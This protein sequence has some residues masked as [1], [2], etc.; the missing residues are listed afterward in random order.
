[1]RV[2]AVVPN[3]NGARWLPACLAA[4]RAQ[5][6]PFDEL[7]V[8][9]N[10]SADGSADGLGPDVAVVRLGRNRG[11]AAAAN[12][13]LRAT[14]ADW[15]ALV[16]SDV[17]LDPG[18]LSA[19]LSATGADDV[20]S[21]AGKM[22]RL[23]DP[24]VIDDAGDFLRRDG[25]CEQRGRGHRDDGRWDEPGEVFSACAGA[26]LLRRGPALAVGGFDERFFSYLEDV[27]LGLRLRL[28]GWRAVYVPAAV[29]RH[30]GGGSA[31]LLRRPVGGWV[32][33][34]TLLLV[35]KAFPLRWAVPV[36]YRQAAWLVA[37]ARGGTLRAHLGGL[38]AALPLLPAM[39][40]ERAALQTRSIVPI[41][42]VVD[43]RPWRGPR[44]GGHPRA[45]F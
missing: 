44:A 13:G 22:V 25:V 10:G 14:D 42:T 35:A 12:A 29:A 4:L 17:E 28:A 9:D 37:A 2:A 27:D 23:D 18:W 7:I 38:A 36:A 32:A 6:R 43:D 34:N 5:T 21:V 39:L 16:N 15:V 31:H 19:M 40:R 41:G 33:R 24:G 20:A 1:M 3:F 11:F 8:V 45:G 26:A 30:A